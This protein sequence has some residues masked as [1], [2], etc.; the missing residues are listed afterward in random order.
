M[1]WGFGVELG[2]VGGPAGVGEVVEEAE[3]EEEEEEVGGF[4]GVVPEG[5]GGRPLRG[6]VC[7]ESAQGGVVAI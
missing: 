5:D 6:H 7:W 4:V 1:R 3:E 2:E